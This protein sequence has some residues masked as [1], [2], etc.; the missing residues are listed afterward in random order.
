MTIRLHDSVRINDEEQGAYTVKCSP[1]S[2]AGNN[3][4]SRSR[5]VMGQ[6]NVVDVQL[7]Q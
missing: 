6:I 3:G 1:H 5:R 4:I 2:V 7:K